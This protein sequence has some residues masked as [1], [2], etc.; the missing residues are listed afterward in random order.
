MLYAYGNKKK[1]YKAILSG[2]AEKDSAKITKLCKD[3]SI[4]I[5]HILNGGTGNLVQLLNEKTKHPVVVTAHGKDVFIPWLSHKEEAINGLR[6]AS[7]IIVPSKIMQNKLLELN[8]KSKIIMHGVDTDFFKKI[9]SNEIISKYKLE[10][11]FIIGTITRIVRRKNLEIVI[12]ALSQIPSAVFIAIGPIEDRLYAKELLNLADS[13]GVKDRFILIGAVS[14]TRPF[15]SILDV[16]VLPSVE[17]IKGDIESFGISILEAQSSSLPVIG[18]KDSGA[19]ELIEHRQTGLLFEHG[20]LQVLVQFLKEL[21]SDTA[22]REELGKSAR[23]FA[24]KQS[25]DTAINK[26]KAIYA[27]IFK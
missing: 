4:D 13:L 14:D 25:W 24:I 8:I 22:F 10:N 17:I 6:K 15:Y 21:E 27:E 18:T 7:K 9:K 5:I 12:Q 19:E 20:N 11:K 3:E 2:N 26:H 1:N 16:F 23:I